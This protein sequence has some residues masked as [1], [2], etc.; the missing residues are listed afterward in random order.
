MVAGA[1]GQPDDTPRPHRTPGRA[2]GVSYSGRFAPSPTGPL[3]A[4]SLVAALA[5]WLDARAHGGRWLVR[6]EDVDRPRCVAGVDAV[7]LQQLARCGLLPDAPPVWQSTRDAAY[8]QALQTLVAGGSAYACGCT[9]KDV[10]DALAAQGVVHQ[11]HGERVYP[12]SCRPERGGLHGRLA[13][14]MR[15]HTGRSG[16]IDWHDRRLGAQRQNVETEVGDFVLRR[17][18]GLWAYQ[19]AVVV[20]DGW[21]GV[22]DVVRGA[23]LADNTPRQILLQRALG[24]PEPRYLHTPLVLGADGNKLSKQNG[25]QAL[26]LADP[27]LAVHQAAQV[28][29]LALPATGTL[30]ETLAAAVR[31]WAGMMAGAAASSSLAPPITPHSEDRTPS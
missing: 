25:A 19:L 30:A 26:D 24:L 4:G 1:V 23:D 14:A 11:R 12:G 5:S 2:T 13:R 22:T 20:D 17:A 29:G 18:D 10:D 6:I 3:H 28:L 16:P 27:A 31:A 9:R 8:A 7:I 15:L 21:R